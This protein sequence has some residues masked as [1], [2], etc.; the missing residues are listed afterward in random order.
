M[1]FAGI[2]SGMKAGLY[3]PSWPDMNGRFIPEVLLNI[4]NWNWLNLTNYDTF[5]FAPA[6]VQFTHRLIG[7]SIIDTN[8]LYL[9]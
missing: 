5:V 7:I 1:I 3:Y 9:F 4:N 6:L 2:M 8:Y